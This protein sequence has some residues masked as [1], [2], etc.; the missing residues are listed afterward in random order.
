MRSRWVLLI[1][2]LLTAGGCGE[3]VERA[4]AVPLGQVPLPA[5]E[6]A[7]KTLPGVKFDLARKIK[8]DGK[9]ALEIRGKDPRGKVREVEVTA[10][11]EVLEIE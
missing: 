11:G 10:S 4:E 2:T 3:T 7:T 9:D 1:A 5:M 8:V 6:A